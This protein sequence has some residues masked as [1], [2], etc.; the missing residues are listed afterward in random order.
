MRRLMMLGPILGCASMIFALAPATAA[1]REEAGP[2]RVHSAPEPACLG[3]CPVALPPCRVG[4]RWYGP[5][6]YVCYRP[7]PYYRPSW[8]N[9]L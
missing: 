8:L 7:E 1:P 4:R 5:Y 6:G 3:A 2:M 9:R